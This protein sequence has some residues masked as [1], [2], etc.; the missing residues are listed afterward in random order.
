[1]AELPAR[2][3]TPTVKGSVK[4][5][6][7]EGKMEVTVTPNGL[8]ATSFD[9]LPPTQKKKTTPQCEVLLLQFL[10]Q[11]VYNIYYV[12]IINCN[13]RQIHF[14]T[15]GHFSFCCPPGSSCLDFDGA[16]GEV[17]GR[18]VGGMVSFFLAASLVGGCGRSNGCKKRWR[19]IHVATVVRVAVLQLMSKKYLLPI[20]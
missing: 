17:N 2:S 8:V 3:I 18:F 12:G 16:T 7:D 11:T 9:L 5:T 1:V 10:T 13:M 15:C 4:R 6:K 19:H 20:I 14:R